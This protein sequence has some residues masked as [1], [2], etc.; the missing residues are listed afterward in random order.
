[1]NGK[2][3]VVLMAS[4]FVAVSLGTIFL[5]WHPQYLV[6]SAADSELAMRGR[7]DQGN[8]EI[9]GAS[10]LGRPAPVGLCACVEVAARKSLTS[11]EIAQLWSFVDMSNG[12]R[13]QP[14]LA[15]PE[16]RSTMTSAM[17]HILPTMP[18][19]YKFVRGN[20]MFRCLREFG[21]LAP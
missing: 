5:I 9:C 1:M 13:K 2:Q 6:Q 20:E 19:V 4:I 14:A 16:A 3:L 10:L 15:V 7:E 17:N 18:N 11:A 8:L 21:G 12:A